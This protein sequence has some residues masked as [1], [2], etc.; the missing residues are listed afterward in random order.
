MEK[1]TIMNIIKFVIRTR[2]LNKEIMKE[3]GITRKD[4]RN[5]YNLQMD[6]VSEIMKRLGE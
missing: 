1:E 2:K 4:L 5:N 3:M 6:V